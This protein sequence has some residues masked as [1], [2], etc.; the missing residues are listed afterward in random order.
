MFFEGAVN[1]SLCTLPCVF[2]EYPVNRVKEIQEN[3]IEFMIGKYAINEI[4]ANHPRM[5]GDNLRT[6]FMQLAL[7]F[8]GE[9]NI[10]ELRALIR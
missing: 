5:H 6:D 3:L 8:L 7:Q 2:S 10:A 4:T 9:E 1:C